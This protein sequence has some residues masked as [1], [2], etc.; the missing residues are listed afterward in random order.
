MLKITDIGFIT[1]TN[2]TQ[3]AHLDFALQIADGDGDTTSVQ[4]LLVGVLN[5]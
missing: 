2:V 3:D 4:H 1:T 5:A